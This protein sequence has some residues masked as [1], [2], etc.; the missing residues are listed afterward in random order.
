[1]SDKIGDVLW[2]R[3]VGKWL[4][5]C[6]KTT[7]HNKSEFQERAVR[8]YGPMGYNDDNTQNAIPQI[9]DVRNHSAVINLWV[10]CNNI[11]FNY[12]PMKNI[13]IMHTSIK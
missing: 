5:E 2:S 9:Y 8:N 1:M 13:E 6:F 11:R 3:Y 10:N 12:L 7:Q 4:F